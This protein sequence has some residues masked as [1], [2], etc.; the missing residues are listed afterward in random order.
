MTPVT[1]IDTNKNVP[2]RHPSL[3]LTASMAVAPKPNCAKAQRTHLDDSRRHGGNGG[4]ERTRWKTVGR[5][6]VPVW[7]P[8][9]GGKAW[10]R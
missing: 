10:E 1:N 9:V 7:V 6:E 2:P 5:P 4:R 3:S 8:M